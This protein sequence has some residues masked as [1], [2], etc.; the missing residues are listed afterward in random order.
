M[1]FPECRR[2]C[3]ELLL[4]RNERT[5]AESSHRDQLLLREILS[6]GN[7]SYT[8]DTD[9]NGTSETVNGVTTAFG[10]D[11]DNQLVPITTGS[12]VAGNAYD[13]LGRR[14]RRTAGG[15]TNSSFH[16][17]GGVIPCGG[18][19]NFHMNIACE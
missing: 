16:D 9:G 4:R 2:K 3:G 8:Y 1:T 7:N 12:N 19:R 17:S 15:V 11:Y 18:V 14:V 13:A 6:A 5:D 10:Y